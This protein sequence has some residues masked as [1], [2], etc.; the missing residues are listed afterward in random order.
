MLI[1]QQHPFVIDGDNKALVQLPER[2]DL[3]R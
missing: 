1:D 3:C 2:L